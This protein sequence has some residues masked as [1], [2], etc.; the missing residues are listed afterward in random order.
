MKGGSKWWTWYIP[1]FTK[2]WVRSSILLKDGTWEHETKGDRKEFYN[3]YWKQKQK[4]WKYNYTDSY[5][6]EVI[7]VTI[8]VEEREWRPKWLTWTK[9]FNTI[10]K[11]I[12]IH[13]SKECGE[14]KGS[15]K[16]GTTQYSYAMLWNETPLDCLRRMEK[17]EMIKSKNNW[18]IFSR[19]KK[20]ERILNDN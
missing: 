6:G 3:A 1:F 12:D 9:K 16:G 20:L 14:R 7:P 10:H 4:S 17:E 13:F 8:Y 19:T 11:S 15:W 18:P 2:C 5:D